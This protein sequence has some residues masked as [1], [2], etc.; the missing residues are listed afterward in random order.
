M[1][2]KARITDADQAPRQLDRLD[3]QVTQFGDQ[4]VVHRRVQTYLQSPY[5]PTPR[6]ETVA[7]IDGSALNNASATGSASKSNPDGLL[8]LDGGTTSGDSIKTESNR[9]L[10]YAPNALGEFSE[11]VQ[12]ENAP[13]DDVVHRFGLFTAEDGLFFEED[14]SGLRAVIRDGSGG[15]VTDRVLQASDAAVLDGKL[16][17]AQALLSSGRIWFIRFSHYGGGKVLFGTRESERID[18]DDP[19]KSERIF[20]AYDATKDELDRLY[21]RTANLPLRHEI[22]NGASSPSQAFTVNVGDRQ[23]SLYGDESA[24][25]RELQQQF[26]GLTAGNETDTVALAIRPQATFG[27]LPNSVNVT[28]TEVELTV[29]GGTNP[30]RFWFEVGPTV[31]G[32]DFNDSQYAGLQSA[33][34][35]GLGNAQTNGNVTVTQDSGIRGQPAGTVPVGK[36]GS[37]P[38]A[39]GGGRSD[40]ALGIQQAAVL[41]VEGQGGAATFDVTLK[42]RE[43]H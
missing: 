4:R 8:T 33:A 27:G 30:V 35:I 18:P 25:P 32:G 21:M 23:L 28:L 11:W 37:A 34:E 6:R 17:L 39:G 3:A 14:A 1:T 10:D 22:D 13:V 2:E 16:Q 42:W 15:T 5:S 7:Q 9:A 38:S 40:T 19:G 26:T 12:R 29:E 41:W 31:T 36:Q 24:Q 43:S 20:L